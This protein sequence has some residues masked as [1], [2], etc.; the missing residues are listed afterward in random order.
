MQ[1][2]ACD[3]DLFFVGF[4]LQCG[5]LF[6]FLSLDFLENYLLG[7]GGFGF[8]SVTLQFSGKFVVVNVELLQSVLGS[9]ETGLVAD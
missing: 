2:V 5:M 1:C 4:L 8:F 9:L 7:G 3:L 6:V